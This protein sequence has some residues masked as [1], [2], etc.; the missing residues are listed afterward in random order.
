MI[1]YPG[2]VGFVQG[3]L[4]LRLMHTVS[5]RWLQFVLS[6][7][8]GSG[9]QLS[10][11]HTLQPE[12]GGER[13]GDQRLPEAVIARDEV[14]PRCERH[15]HL[16]RERNHVRRGNAVVTIL[17]LMQ[18]LDQQIAT[19]RGIAEQGKNFLKRLRIDPATFRS[20]ANTATATSLFFGGR[21][22]GGRFSRRQSERIFHRNCPHA[23]ICLLSD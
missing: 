13:A 4:T 5:K 17:D 3:R 12:R 7:A 8:G 9:W 1:G 6:A 23:I 16:G 18:V 21:F 15:L 10:I 20:R 2:R 22:G 11:Q 14:E 19:P